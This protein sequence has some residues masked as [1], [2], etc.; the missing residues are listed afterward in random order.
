MFEARE[1]IQCLS[2]PDGFGNTYLKGSYSQALAT[3]GI[4]NCAYISLYNSK[5][6]VHAI[7]HVYATDNKAGIASTINVLMPNGFDKVCIIAGE[8]EGT[9]NCAQEIF[10]AVKSIKKS[11]KIV[12][13]HFNQESPAII[14]YNGKVYELSKE[15]KNAIAK[16]PDKQDYSCHAL[17]NRIS[18]FPL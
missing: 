18:L 14:S 1:K 16:I 13:R 7:H 3:Q 11:T 10:R 6:K 8:S 15:Q 4:Y 9:E 12:Y 5:N 17:T 2:T